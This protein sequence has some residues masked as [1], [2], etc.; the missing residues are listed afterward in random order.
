MSLATVDHIGEEVRKD[1]ELFFR[2]EAG[3]G[4]VTIDGHESKIA[5]GDGIMVPSGARHKIA[6]AGEEP[7][8]LYAIYRPPHHSDGYVAA[9]KWEDEGYQEDF[10][11]RTTEPTD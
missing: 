7:L 5:I 11:G 3:T 8:R 1:G 9:T 4:I 2:I 6:N 10:D